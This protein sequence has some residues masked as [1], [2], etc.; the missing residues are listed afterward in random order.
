MADKD[1]SLLIKVYGFKTTFERLPVKGDPL[2]DTLDERGFKVDDKGK[3]VLE[4]QEVDWVHYAPG[5]SP[6]NTM[7]WERVKHMEVTD[8]MLA[9]E[10]TEKLK[11]MRARWSM[12]QPAYV[13]WKS[14]QDMPLNG[15]PLAAWAGV[16]AEKA[17]VLRRFGIR[18]VE[19]VAT[20]AESQ[21]EKI[22]LPA[23]RDMRKAAKLFLD[24]RGAAEAAER[25]AERDKEM[26]AMRARLKE[27]EE[28][29]AAAM[30][31]LEEK[32]N[33]AGEIEAL[34]AQCDAA[35]IKYHHKAGVD[36]LRSL[37]AQQAA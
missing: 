32:A 16:T 26:E 35:G 25:E 33:P 2:N 34:R 23:M 30:D 24:G 1:T 17:E 7:T 12:I 18:T 11:L 3:R 22:P 29:L 5:H 19:D 13:A 4:M 14:G 8:A 37:L 31:L 10:E 9:G 27:Q 21:I 20:L 6:Q 15:T 28:R 36:T